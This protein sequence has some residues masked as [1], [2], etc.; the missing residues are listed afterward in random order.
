MHEAEESSL[1]EAVLRELL[2]E[3]LKAGDDLACSDL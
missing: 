2:L 3:T 1:L